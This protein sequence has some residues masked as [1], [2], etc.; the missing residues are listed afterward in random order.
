MIGIIVAMNPD[1]LIGINNR[2]PWTYRGDMARFKRV[3]MGSTVIMG[4]KTWE[5]IPAKF[6]PLPGRQNF[7]LSQTMREAQLDTS[8]GPGGMSAFDTFKDA[9]DAADNETTWVIGGAAV[10]EIA[11]HYADV[12]DVTHVPDRCEPGFG[13][14]QSDARARKYGD[15]VSEDARVYF[16]PIDEAV[17]MPGPIELHPDEPALRIQRFE[18]RYLNADNRKLQEAGSLS[19]GSR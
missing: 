3:T 12:I 10:Y 2:I 13:T 14:V 17:F 15:A 6:R 1:R 7:V 8:R 18:R 19:R 16:P 5:S 4:R 9:R 11:M